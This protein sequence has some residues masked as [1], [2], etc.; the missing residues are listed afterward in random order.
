[1]IVNEFQKRAL[2]LRMGTVG[3]FRQCDAHYLELIRKDLELDLTVGDLM[4]LQG[5][6]RALKRDPYVTELYFCA[7]G[8]RSACRFPESVIVPSL[9]S[10]DPDITQLFGSL[11]SRYNRYYGG[12][13]IPPSLISLAEFAAFT[14]EARDR[15][16]SLGFNANVAISD[17]PVSCRPVIGSTEIIDTGKYILT[18][19]QG[20]QMKIGQREFGTMFFPLPGC[21][22]QEFLKRAYSLFSIAEPSKNESYVLPLSGRGL[23]RDVAAVCR[24]ARIDC[25]ALPG[26]PYFADAVFGAYT[27]SFIIFCDAKDITPLAEKAGEYG[28]GF[29]VPIRTTGNRGFTVTS[30]S[31]TLPVSMTLLDALDYRVPI[32]LKAGREKIT[33]SASGDLPD[34]GYSFQCKKLP[35]S[36]FAEELSG[37]D[38][39]GLLDRKLPSIDEENKDFAVLAGTLS[40]DS[41]D[42]VPLILTIDA[43]CR[44]RNRRIAG[45]NFFLEKKNSLTLF[46]ISQK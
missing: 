16:K 40:A 6:F 29:S 32:E 34:N 10:S 23:I 22:D 45:A 14:P 43:V 13:E 9:S 21:S 33:L 39:Y 4:H 19:S 44:N 8:I 26:M 28:V 36:L 18:L 24:D 15:V 2:P 37:T 5:V 42:T 30:S 12:R 11:V 41:P 20:A 25:G 35:C 46:I 17:S 31:G 27:P 3:N 1:M 38:V 7:A